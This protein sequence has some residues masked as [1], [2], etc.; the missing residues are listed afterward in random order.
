MCGSGCKIAGTIAFRAPP[1]MAAFGK[2]VN[3]R[4]ESFAEVHGAMSC[5]TPEPVSVM[6]TIRKVVNA[7]GLELQD[8]CNNYWNSRLHASRQ[9]LLDHNLC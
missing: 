5:H 3:A 2:A 1:L 6:V 9:E 7:A 4:P 8:R